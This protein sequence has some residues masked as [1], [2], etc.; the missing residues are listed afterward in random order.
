MNDLR[1]RGKVVLA[2][3]VALGIGMGAWFMASDAGADLAEAS[4]IDT[5]FVQAKS[6]VEA[7]RYIIA[8]GGCNDCHT[9]GYLMTGGN[10]PEEQ[11]MLGDMIGWR[12]PWGTTYPS[13]LRLFVQEFEDDQTWVQVLRARNTRPPMPWMSLHHMSDAD[14]KAVYAYLRHLGPAGEKVP[15]YVPPDQEP[16]TPF[17]LLVPQMPAQAGG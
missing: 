14:L 9:A 10:V 13:N 8:A 17:L 4:G 11:W 16:K 1:K 2:G 6:P 15:E 5:P 3:A 7:E 12:G